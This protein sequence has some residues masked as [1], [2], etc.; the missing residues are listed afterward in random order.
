LQL[1]SRTSHTPVAEY[2]GEWMSELLSVTGGQLCVTLRLSLPK[3]FSVFA[4]LFTVDKEA[5]IV[6]RAESTPTSADATDLFSM[7]EV[8]LT[9]DEDG[10]DDV[11]TERTVQMVV[12]VSL[13]V[14]IKTVSIS[15]GQ[16][17]YISKYCRFVIR[18][19]PLLSVALLHFKRDFSFSPPEI[20]S[21]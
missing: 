1:V 19:V 10:D 15:S 13:N 11:T 5:Q 4:K 12:Y 8:K 3:Q 7:F 18:V 16:C 14:A 2:E 21:D 6:Y 9:E 17:P 20:K